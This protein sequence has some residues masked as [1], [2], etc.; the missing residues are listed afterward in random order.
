[1]RLVWNERAKRDLDEL[2]SYI[3]QDSVQNALLVR[4]RLLQAGYLLA[5]TPMI[6]KVNP[7]QHCREW[8]VR[9]TGFV[10]Q[11]RVLEDIVVVLTVMRGTRQR[12]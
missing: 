9:R 7:R 1:M 2:T 4:E 10:L 3:A 6:G 8:V 12:G 5:L 11:Y